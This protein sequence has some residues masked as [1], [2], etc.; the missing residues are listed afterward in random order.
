[1]AK[2]KKQPAAEAAQADQSTATNQ[3]D[4][5][6]PDASKTTEALQAEVDKLQQQLDDSQNDYL[7]SQ[8]E[9]QNMQKRNQKEQSELAK[10]G[11]Q[12]LAKDIVPAL[13]DLTR[14]L[15][16]QVDDESGRQLKTGIEMVVKHLQKALT[17]NDIH[18][19]DEV[20]VKFDP[21]VHQAVQTVP[22]SDE[23]PADTVVQVLQTGYRLA[24]RII[25]PAMV[26]VAQ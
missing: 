1:M 15:N 23:H 13:D 9:I 19:I 3:A 26:I 6:Q 17:D 24:D 4:Q 11:S 25:R 7:R 8:A 10:Y 18:A 21:E 22:A 12:S 16:V 5:A 2:D 14:A 20:G